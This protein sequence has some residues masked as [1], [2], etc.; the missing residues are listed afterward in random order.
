LKNP[1]YIVDAD[2]QMRLR[3]RALLEQAGMAC[4]PFQS[5]SDLIEAMPRLP[6]GIVLIDIQ[7][8]GD[9]GFSVIEAI[10]RSYLSCPIIGMTNAADVHIAV[11]C[12]RRGA[13]D[14]LVKPIDPDELASAVAGAQTILEQR[15][16]VFEQA[17]QDR[18][19]LALLK[20]R[21][22]FVLERIAEGL[23][24]KEIAQDLEIGVRT[25]EMYRTTIVEKLKVPNSTAAAAL[26][27][28]HKAVLQAHSARI[29]AAAGV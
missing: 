23:H 28:R 19:L 14:F 9:N 29:V 10:A 21:E 1:V 15:R 12:I 5:G 13:V 24:S 22:Q 16:L 11:A 3:L 4:H 27:A 17:E 25:V 2:R 20:P 6:P 26:L 7:N 8:A 18:H